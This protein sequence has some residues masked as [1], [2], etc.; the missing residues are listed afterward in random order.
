[1]TER[2]VEIKREREIDTEGERDFRRGGREKMDL[3]V[4]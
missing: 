2:E 3:A 1:M 4:G